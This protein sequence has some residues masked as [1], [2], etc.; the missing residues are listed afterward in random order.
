MD[1]PWKEAKKMVRIILNGCYGKMGQVISSIA[2]DDEGV[3][4]AAGIDIREDA[5]MQAA[6]P[7]FKSIASISPDL[8]ADVML[9][10]SHPTVMLAERLSYASDK[11][12]PIVIATT[13]FTDEGK[14]MIAECSGKVGVFTSANMSIGVNL[15]GDLAAKAARAIGDVFDVEIV[16]S[17]HGQKL[18]APSGTAYMIADKVSKA[19]SYE[20]EYIY[21]RHGRS[22][23]RGPKEIGMH[24]IRGG[25]TVGEH[26]VIFAG[27]DEVIEIRHTA[28]S[29][30]L[31]AVGAMKA[32]K[33]MKGKGPGMY[34]MGSLL[35][36]SD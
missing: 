32:A 35:A 6:Y 4:I 1:N 36:E 17:H 10:F 28:L 13:G 15:L 11:G 7:V 24:A 26:T 12:V 9:D 21:D 16:E 14:A 34:D 27:L 2:K 8:C 29:R 19:L 20:P 22:E 31:F 3:C 25:T 30:S 33:F 5:P 23:R 18:D